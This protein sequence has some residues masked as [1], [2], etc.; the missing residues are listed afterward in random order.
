MQYRTQSRLCSSIR[1]CGLGNVESERYTCGAVAS[2]FY[3]ILF[4]GW[5]LSLSLSRYCSTGAAYCV[6]DVP[7]PL[8]KAGNPVHL[9]QSRWAASGNCNRTSTFLCGTLKQHAIDETCFSPTRMLLFAW[10][11]YTAAEL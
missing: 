3:F 10:P 2:T 8:R 9:Q 6:L 11:V 1:I 4:F 7:L 5:G